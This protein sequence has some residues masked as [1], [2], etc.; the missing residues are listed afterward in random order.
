MV[1]GICKGG[2]VNDKNKNGSTLLHQTSE[3]GYFGTCLALWLIRK[4]ANINAVDKNNETT[5]M[6]GICLVRYLR[7]QILLEYGVNPH[8]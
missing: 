3:H 1:Q 6:A 4:G 7:V 8:I 2:S 5:L